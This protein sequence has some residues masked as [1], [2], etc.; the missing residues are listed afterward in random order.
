M[1]PDLLTTKAAAAKLSCTEGNVRRLMSIGKL[2]KTNLGGRRIYTTQESVD[3]YIASGYRSGTIQLADKRALDVHH[4]DL[5]NVIRTLLQNR[6]DY[7]WAYL[8]EQG[9]PR[10]LVETSEG[11]RNLTEHFE[12][13][14]LG[15][16]P[17]TPI[18]AQHPGISRTLG[19]HL[20][21]WLNLRERYVSVTEANRPNSYS[22]CRNQIGD[23]LKN[24]EE[25]QLS[26]L[27]QV[28][29]EPIFPGTCYICK[30]YYDS[31]PC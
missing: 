28:L 17:H 24:N 21:D 15:T 27:E 6:R 9:E 7:F 2:E 23:E 26:I 14:P 5:R 29:H 20:P 19:E 8:L 25:E 13:M 30:K 18:E 22:V 10:V 1:K 11:L 4:D 12:T 16:A 3:R 31:Q